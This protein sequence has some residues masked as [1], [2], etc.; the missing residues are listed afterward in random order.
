[1]AI[2][3]R[4]FGVD[5]MP[6][7]SPVNPSLVAFNPTALT[8]GLRSGVDLKMLLEKLAAQKAAAEE[9]ALTKDKRIGA[10][11]TINEVLAAR[12]QKDLRQMP[13][14]EEIEGLKHAN[15]RATV[16]LQGKYDLAKL[17]VDL[18]N[19][20]PLGQAQRETALTQTAA[21]QND[22]RIMPQV[23]DAK[24]ATADATTA[25]AGIAVRTAKLREEGVKAQTAL[26]TTL[27]TLQRMNAPAAN[28]VEIIKIYDAIA[29]SKDDAEL[30]RALTRAQIELMKS[31][32]YENLQSK[33]RILTPDQEIKQIQ[34]ALEQLEKLRV[35]S[36]E[37]FGVYRQ[38]TY[39]G[40]NLEQ[41]KQPGSL[42][43]AAGKVF[44]FEPEGAA[45]DPQGEIFKNEYVRLTRRMAEL[46]GA[47]GATPGDGNKQ[48]SSPKASQQ[49]QDA[50]AW[51]TNPANA[52]DPRL[53]RIKEELKKAGLIQ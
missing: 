41:P 49:Y 24:A 5:V 33:G 45:Q 14:I 8:D 43:K 37:D 16:P 40:G 15:D 51:A 10:T 30:K 4:G 6:Q 27:A 31:Q 52:N 18:E 44:G 9:N 50:L 13:T 29:N 34:G 28:T 47:L 19:V 11:N 3:T 7:Y 36:G 35:S 39:E 32:S 2:N 53:P 46:Q 38:N 22:R 1:M 23:Y 25:D 42:K 48:S 26:S 20:A 17:G 12:G 21:A